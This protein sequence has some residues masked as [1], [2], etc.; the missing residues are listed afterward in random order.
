MHS[1]RWYHWLV[2]AVVLLITMCV[3]VL[4]LVLGASEGSPFFTVDNIL[5]RAIGAGF[6]VS[7]ALMALRRKA[8]YVLA[9][10]CFLLSGL[11]FLVTWLLYQPPIVGIALAIF[12]AICALL[13]GAAMW[14]AR[15]FVR[16]TAGA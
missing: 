14:I 1:P 6:L 8:G 12:L 13:S 2:L 15:A 16:P 9:A 3:G 7:A 10:A 4:D 5:V 11:E